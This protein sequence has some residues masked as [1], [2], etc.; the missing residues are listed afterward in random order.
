LGRTIIIIAGGAFLMATAA[1]GQDERMDRPEASRRARVP[2]VSHI[3]TTPIACASRHPRAAARSPS[4][5][6]ESMALDADMIVPLDPRQ[7]VRHP[8]EP[9]REPLFELIR[10]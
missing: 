8:V 7:V 4:A 6:E 10:S 1:V 9:A 2:Q 3:G 5:Y